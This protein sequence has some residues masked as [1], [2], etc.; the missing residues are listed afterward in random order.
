MRTSLTLGCMAL[1]VAVLISS[2]C[3]L[4]GTASPPTRHWVL[5]PI[6]GSPADVEPRLVVGIGPFSLPAYLDRREVVSRIGANQLRISEFDLWGEQLDRSFSQVLARNLE[7]LIP[8]TATSVFPWK[9]V[10]EVEYRVMG[11]VSRFEV[12]DDRVAQLE[13]SWTLSRLSDQR[14]LAR[15]VQIIEEPLAAMGVAEGVAALSRALGRLSNDIASP[16]AAQLEAG[17]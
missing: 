4:P 3:R 14:V 11:E 10:A 15:G 8:G 2:G 12:V 1:V 13:T 9:G 5:E 17:S 7:V 6:A 16:I